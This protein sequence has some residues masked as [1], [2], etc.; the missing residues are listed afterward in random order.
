MRDQKRA[1]EIAVERMQLLSPLLGEEMDA[2][3]G[4]TN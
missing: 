2:G 1:E 4:Q 3:Q